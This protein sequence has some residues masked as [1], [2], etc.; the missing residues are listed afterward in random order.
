[1][2]YPNGNLPKPAPKPTSSGYY[3]VKIWSGY[4]SGWPTE[5][6]IIHY[7]SSATTYPLSY[8]GSDD[9]GDWIDD[10]YK[11]VVEVGPK[12]EEPT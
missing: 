4:Q 12:I 9:I 5:W 8:F 7:D 6:K 11:V 2:R 3:W 1:M 10:G